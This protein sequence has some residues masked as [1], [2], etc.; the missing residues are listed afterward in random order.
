[1]M[2]NNHIATYTYKLI[3]ANETVYKYGLRRV[4]YGKSMES[5]NVI[6]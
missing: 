4:T 1:M 3:T 2:Y 6:G 5:E